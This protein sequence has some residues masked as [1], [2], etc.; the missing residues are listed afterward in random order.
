MYLAL[1]RKS[2]NTATV[3]AAKGALTG[4]YLCCNLGEMQ[5]DGSVTSRKNATEVADETEAIRAALA[6]V[7]GRADPEVWHVVGVS[8]QA[9]E[10]RSWARSGAPGKFA[11]LAASWHSTG[12]IVD[13]EPSTNYSQAHAEAYGRFLEGLGEALRNASAAGAGGGSQREMRAGMD[14]AGW[15]ILDQPFWHAYAAASLGRYTSMSPT[16]SGADLLKDEAF[17]KSALAGPLPAHAVAF[18]LGTELDSKC[19][20]PKW[21]YHWTEAPL[22]KFLADLASRGALSVDLWRADIDGYCAEGTAPWM[23]DAVRDFV[24]GRLG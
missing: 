11:E 4:A 24:S 8:Q 5:A 1:G 23:L 15:G 6:S 3:R 14:F 13:Y 18:G 12:L 2:E 19:P 9:I 17:A 21:Q 7:T 20:P 10:S 16:Y 22:R